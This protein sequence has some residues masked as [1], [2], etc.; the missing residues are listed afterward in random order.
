LAIKNGAANFAVKAEKSDQGLQ[1][2]R[3]F[4]LDAN[5]FPTDRYWAMRGFVRRVAVGDEEQ[6]ALKRLAPSTAQAN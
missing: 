1:I 5:Y 3:S 6:V 4:V 2:T